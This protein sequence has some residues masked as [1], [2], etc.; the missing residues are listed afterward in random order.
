MLHRAIGEVPGLKSRVARLA[1]GIMVRL[2]MG[3]SVALATGGFLVRAIAAEGPDLASSARVWKEQ[4]ATKILPY[5]YETTL[6]KTN[7]GYVLSDDAAKPARPAT[8]KQL[9]TQARLVWGF[10]HAH[11]KGFSDGKHDYLAAASHGVKFLLEK[12]RDAEQGGYFWKVDLAGRPVVD[13][14]YLYGESFVIYALVEYHRASGD[15]AALEKAMELFHVIQEKCHDLAHSGWLEH[16][17]RDWTPILQQDGLIEVEVAGL[18]SANAHLHWMEALAELAEATSNEEVS[19]A[20]SEALRLNATQFYPRDS[21]KSAFHRNPDWSPVT[22][23]KSAG[24]S[25]GHNV[26]FAWLMIRAEEVLGR[27]P[28]WGHFE[29]ILDHALRYGY[30]NARGGLYNRGFENQPASDRDKVWWSQA[31][32][33]AALTYSLKHQATASRREA[34]EKLITFIDRYQAN[35]GDRIWLDTVTEDGRPKST[36]KAHNWKA[37]YHDV[38]GML[39]FIDGLG[40]KAAAKP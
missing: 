25:Y 35:P 4:L 14:K 12:M 16:A 11:R 3:W 24:L 1:T 36:A 8:E 2:V 9:V 28:S 23:P 38:R 21:A 19:E 22:D 13:R 34:L 29:A 27:K 37:N 6:D 17:Q 39:I 5:W 32:M 10:S 33:V 31:E 26:E 18:R 40:E 15:K 20:L 30:D 7:G